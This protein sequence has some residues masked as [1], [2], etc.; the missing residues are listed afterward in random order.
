MMFQPLLTLVL[1]ALP[2]AAS[3]QQAVYL[4]RHADRDPNAPDALT[5]AGRARAQALA[6]V[7]KDTGLT[8]VVRSDT[9]RTRDTAAPVVKAGHLAEKVSPPDA[10]HVQAAHHAI[11]AAG[12]RAVVLYVG[13]SDTI[14]PL[15]NKLGYPGRVSFEDDEYGNLWIL[16]PQASGPPSLLRLHYGAK[17]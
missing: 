17:P 7:L 8:V 16:L 9:L 10:R 15:L 2:A 1:L 14:G 11:C 6:R 13:H 3:A 5:D 4:V 12:P